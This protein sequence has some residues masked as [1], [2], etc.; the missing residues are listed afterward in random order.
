MEEKTA[1][2]IRSLILSGM[3][4]VSSQAFFETIVPRR[5][6]RHEWIEYTVIPAFTAG[7][8]I[9]AM[10]KIPPYFLQ[11]VRVILVLVFVAQVYFQLGILR[12][13]VL[14]VGYC[15]IYWIV[16]V[17]F[18]AVA[19]VAVVDSRGVVD[20]LEPLLDVCYLC[21]MLLFR[22]RYQK[23]VRG[24]MDLKWEKVGFFSLAGII[25]S[26]GLA[27]G[28]AT[29]EDS[30]AVL[31]LTVGFAAIYLIGFYYMVNLLEKEAQMQKLRLAQERAQNQIRLYQ[32]MKQHYEQQRRRQ[33]DH[34]NELHCIQGLIEGG[35]KEEALRYIANLTGNFK[36]RQLCVNTNHSVVNVILNQKYV[37][38]C[39]SQITMTMV[40]NDL[41]GLT[42]SEEDLVVLL[43]NL[44]DNALEA[45]EKLEHNRVIQVKM[46]LEEEQFVLAVRNPAREPVQSKDNRILTS[47][48]DKERHGIG[49]LNVDDVIRRNGGTS[50]LKWEDGWFS[51]T[52][53]IP[54]TGVF[55]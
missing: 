21:L 8:M 33:H 6:L 17:L 51:F 35:K 50:V 38:A 26:M 1:L 10:T 27:S 31:A 43:G 30:Y 34:R 4:A 24:F 37:Q 20:L 48:R 32:D 47:K 39:D 42:V 19:R 46:V 13:L 14:S 36:Q 29:V 22:Y 16:S 55:F 5:R 41:S 15:G 18:C 45:C 53:V 44:L 12:N 23:R 9:I 52:A 7:F 49:L 2:L 40:C 11:P 3:M 25:L 54:V 28:M